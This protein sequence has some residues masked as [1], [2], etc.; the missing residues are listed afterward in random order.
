MRNLG[1][2]PK[3]RV[4]EVIALVSALWNRTDLLSLNFLQIQKKLTPT[5]DLYADG[6]PIRDMMMQYMANSKQS[7][8]KRRKVLDADKENLVGVLKYSAVL[9]LM[10]IEICRATIRGMTK[11]QKIMIFIYQKAMMG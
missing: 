9:A 10:T 2:Y 1:S 3:L 5:F 11:C 4:A 7:A 8:K 6:W